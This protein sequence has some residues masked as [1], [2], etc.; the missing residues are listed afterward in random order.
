MIA[1][2]SN[3]TVEQLT[4][5]LMVKD[6]CSR[7]NY[8][9]ETTAFIESILMKKFSPRSITVLNMK[10]N[11]GCFWFAIIVALYTQCGK[12]TMSR[13]SV[14]EFRTLVFEF[15]KEKSAQFLDLFVRHHLHSEK[16]Q[17]I[18]V[19]EQLIKYCDVRLR[20]RHRYAEEFDMIAAIT[21]LQ[22]V[23]NSHVIRLDKG[24]DTFEV[25][26]TIE[27]TPHFEYINK[28]PVFGPSKWCSGPL[29]LE[30]VQYN[31]HYW[32][33]DDRGKS[34]ELKVIFNPALVDVDCSQIEQTKVSEELD[35]LQLITDLRKKF[36][37]Q[38]NLMDD[39]RKAQGLDNDA[40]SKTQQL[41]DLR[42]FALEDPNL[43]ERVEGIVSG[44]MTE[45]IIQEKYN[46][47]MTRR[48]LVCLKP[49]TW[50]NDEVINF[51]MNML[52]ERDNSLCKNFTSRRKSHFFNS[53][54]VERLLK[55]D[56]KYNYNNVKRWSKKFD[57]FALDKIFFPIN[58]DNMH[59]TLAVV[60]PQ[61]KEIHYFDSMRGK[62]QFYM[63]GLRDWIRDEALMKNNAT[64]DT[65]EWKLISRSH[66]IPQQGNGFDCG[67]FTIVSADFLSDD[68][69]L[70]EQSYSQTKMPFF[71]LKIC[72]DILKGTLSY[73]L[74]TIFL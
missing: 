46:T 57:I 54:F 42:Y 19:E 27:I 31:E 23:I 1:K 55:T 70:N 11:G 8:F 30:V 38:S 65:S 10:P 25:V 53:F 33:T 47:I 14:L 69:P 3:C 7:N 32:T 28:H 48:K 49:N 59:W 26:T 74:T 9:A 56:K 2:A 60:Y 34:F 16:E 68:L 15:I 29:V 12:I 39:D 61:L 72:Y 41:I 20:E 73:P 45:D 51:Y 4:P 21:Y 62:G 18:G 22:G 24:L 63:E 43:L 5:I 6:D 44:P 50:L 67:T 13:S 40:P 52:M 35:Y 66:E 17:L 71:R 64:L 36:S 58:I 37:E